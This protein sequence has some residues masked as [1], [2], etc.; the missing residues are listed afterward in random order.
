MKKQ[1]PNQGAVYILFQQVEAHDNGAQ[2]HKDN[3]GGAVQGLRRGFV[4]KYRC[5]PRPDQREHHAQGKHC[6][7]RC[8]ADGKVGNGAGQRGEGHDEHAGAHRGF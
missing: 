6:P 3:A 5:D 1:H 8:A 7:V 2:Q 4:G